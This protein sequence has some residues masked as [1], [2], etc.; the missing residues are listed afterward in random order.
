MVG[1]PVMPNFHF[2]NL[3]W[4]RTGEGKC[5]SR[6][7]PTECSTTVWVKLSGWPV[8]MSMLPNSWEGHYRVWLPRERAES[9]R[10][11]SGTSPYQ[12][13]H[14]PLGC[15]AICTLMVNAHLT[16]STAQSMLSMRP[17]QAHRRRWLDAACP[18]LRSSLK[19]SNT[20]RQ[21]YSSLRIYFMK[22]ENAK[23]VK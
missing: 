2:Q 23:N 16:G 19:G 12:L 11:P 17:C 6:E 21:V 8:L 9:S 15:Q 5:Y 7:G 4:P 18:S 3:N 10:V 1:A 20:S 14:A 22:Y 13:A